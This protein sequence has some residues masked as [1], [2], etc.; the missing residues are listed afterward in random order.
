MGQAT[1]AVSQ[2]REVECTLRADERF[3][4]PVSDGYS[5]YSAL[6][7]VLDEV[8][9][10]V[11]TSV[12]DSPMGS[13]H[14]SGLVGAFGSS[15]RPHHKTV[16]SGEEYELSLG[17]VHPDD[18]D[19]FQALVSALVLEGGIIELSHGELRVERF[20]SENATHEDLVA[21]AGEY[22]DP[23]IEMEFQTPTCIEEAG[24]VTT[25]FPHRLPMF[26]SLAGKW[27][28]SCPAELEIELYRE[29]VL[30]SVIEKPHVPGY[31]SGYEYETHSVLVNRVD[32]ED[33]EN[34]NIIRQGFTGI[35]EYDFK[36]ASESVENAITS[37]AMFAP[38]SG[39]GSAVARGCGSVNIEVI[40]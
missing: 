3:P 21:K 20:E 33:G 1:E 12:H 18:T 14:S 31:K 27:N 23:T 11:S 19:V 35:C 28:N 4:V 32:G 6:L 5:V 36:N 2:L 30:E 13:L 24:N 34:R 8:D 15:D 17:I 10:S 39:V 26:N 25:A 38:Y 37:L 9:A 40:E 22:D 29:M 16:L 7:G